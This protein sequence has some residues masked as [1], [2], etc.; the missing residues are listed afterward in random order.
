MRGDTRKTKLII[1]LGHNHLPSLVVDMYGLA[2]HPFGS[3]SG[4]KDDF[5][6]QCRPR[7]SAQVAGSQARR[8][9]RR[10]FQDLSV[11]WDWPGE[12]LSLESS[13]PAA[14]G[15]WPGEAQARTKEPGQPDGPRD[16]REGSTSAADLSSGAH[17]D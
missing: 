4:R 17:P 5:D 10:H 16:R 8:A 3:R 12:L 15:S 7:Y 6:E 11:F 13:L 9:D 14:G 2:R 1:E